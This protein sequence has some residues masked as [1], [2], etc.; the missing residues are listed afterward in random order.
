MA[1]E[2]G[3]SGAEQGHEHAS[4]FFGGQGPGRQVQ[5]PADGLGDLADGYAFFADGVE[6]CADRGPARRPARRRWLAWRRIG[7]SNS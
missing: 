5:V 1:L 3:M 7:D 2:A 6:H 4:E